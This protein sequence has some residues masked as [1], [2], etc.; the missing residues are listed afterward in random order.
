MTDVVSW[1]RDVRDRRGGR[2]ANRVVAT[3]S[4]EAAGLVQA[5]LDG[6][7]GAEQRARVTAHLELCLRCGLDARIYTEI[8][9]AL[10]RRR[11]PVDELLVL[12]LTRFAESLAGSGR[13]RSEDR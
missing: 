4:R 8:K 6:E 2:P 3:D 12:R 11:A 13:T 9:N 5:Y 10:A 1:W 7:V